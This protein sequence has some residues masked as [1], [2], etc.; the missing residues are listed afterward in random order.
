MPALPRARPRRCR[1]RGRGRF[2]RG[3]LG[4]LADRPRVEEAESADLLPRTVLE[5]LHFLG[6]QVAHRPSLLVAHDHVQQHDLGVDAED[7]APQLGRGFLRSGGREAGGDADEQ[8]G[9]AAER[10]HGFGAGSE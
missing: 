1:R 9:R 10:A 5:D 4:G 3:F 7:V 6:S 8:Q 2:R